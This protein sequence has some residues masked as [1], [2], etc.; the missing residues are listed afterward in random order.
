MPRDDEGDELID[1]LVLGEGVASLVA[2]REQ[3]A[4]HVVVRAI[5]LAFDERREIRV[6]CSRARLKTRP[7]SESA[8]LSLKELEGRDHRVERLDDGEDLCVQ[9]LHAGRVLLAED[10]LDDDVERDL[11]GD[12][13]DRHDAIALERR[14][15]ASRGALRR[16]GVRA[17]S[18]AVKGGREQRAC[19]PMSGS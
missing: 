8:E 3:Q 15:P 10:R 18:L 14:G 19:A 13:E 5:A 12:R 1:D 7:R 6:Q 9:R 2:G 11:L 17:G 4:E 16:L